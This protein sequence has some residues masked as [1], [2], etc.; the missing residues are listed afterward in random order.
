MKDIAHEDW[1]NALT[2][3]PTVDEADNLLRRVV[4]MSNMK[5]DLLLGLTVSEL[6]VALVNYRISPKIALEIADHAYRGLASRP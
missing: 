2:G 1:F 4:D 3:D 5:H 6:R